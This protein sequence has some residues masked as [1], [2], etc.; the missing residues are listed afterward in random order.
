M[1]QIVG[2]V[3]IVFICLVSSVSMAGNAPL[4]KSGKLSLYVLKS[5]I[6]IEGAELV[7]DELKVRFTD[8]DGAMHV[9]LPAGDYSGSVVINSISLT[10]LLFTVI[11]GEQTQVIVHKPADNIDAVVQIETSVNKLPGQSAGGNQNAIDLNKNNAVI[12][13]KVS[14]FDS[15]KPLGSAKIFISGVNKKIVSDEEGLFEVSL[16]AGMYTL[17]VVM[18]GFNTY[19]IKEIK[20]PD[21]GLINNDIE[22]VPTGVKLAEYLVTAPD[23][24]GS[25]MA[26]EEEK[27]SASTVSEIIGADQMSQ[28]GD[29]DAAGALKRVTGLTLVDGKYI[30]VR[31]L[32]DRY[33]STLLNYSEL[34][35]VDPTRRAVPLDLFPT[36]ALGSVVIQKT[37]SPDLPGDFAGGT[38]ILRTKGIPDNKIRKISLSVGGNSRS[39][40]KDGLTYEGGSTDFIG[41]DDGTREFPPL[42]DALTDGGTK[43]LVRLSD[44]EKEAAGESLANNYATETKKLPPDF[45]LKLNFANR[46][47]MYGSN[48]GWGYNFSFNYKNEWRQR[49][50]ERT[51]FSLDGQGGLVAADT[52]TREKTGNNIDLGAMLNLSAEIGG[53]HILESNTLITRNTTDTVFRD[54]SFLSE[55][56]LNVRDTTLEWVERELINQQF[57]GKHTFYSLNDL[58]IDWHVAYS[59]ANR[60]EPDT[61][62]YRYERQDDGRF[63]FSQEGQ[64]NERTFETLDDE[65]IST[66]IDFTLPVYELFSR[67]A[68]LKAGFAFKENNRESSFVRFRFLTDWSNNNLDPGI[69]YAENPEGILNEENIDPDGYVLRNTTLPTDNYNASQEIASTYLMGEFSLSDSFSFMAGARAEDNNQSVTTFQLTSPEDSTSVI[70]SE[71]DIMPAINATWA[72]SKD[73]QLRFAY[74]ETVNRPDSKELS[75]A[76]YVDAETRDIVI[77]NPNLVKANISSVDIRWE[78]YFSKFE[79]ISVAVFYKEFEAPIERVIRLGA[80]GINTFDN[81]ESAEN[82]GVEFQS[83]FWLSRFF[84]KAASN[85]YMDTNFALIDSNVVLGDAGAQQTN[86]ERA[87]QGQSPWAVNLSLNYENLINEVKSA[88]LFNMSGKRIVNVGTGGLPDAY[89]NPVPVLDFIYSRSLTQGHEDKWGI[90][91]KIQNIL[92]K[93]I[94]TTRGGEVEKTYRAGVTFELALK[95]SWK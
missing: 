15:G 93:E 55:N 59:T 14:S 16:P 28:S 10:D 72:Y 1:K 71:T 12:R 24:E 77:G 6:P 65:I 13:G 89:E 88:L 50:E 78:K 61:R 53:N 30:Y 86:N 38:V 17:S 3:L 27:R 37:Y 67:P 2:A 69:L 64:S 41:I 83:R 8:A 68:K 91:I 7:L 74:S 76:P 22:L 23:L 47:E 36:G 19:T 39:T 45:G 42:L 43:L 87:L 11:P 32:G 44:E 62:F 92:D 70:I 75:E 95:Y 5:G 29:S 54:N 84:G 35:S 57:N 66:G 60:Y 25:A 90:K 51:S 21:A 33:S 81:A 40:F 85:L 63:S 79:N 31:G 9:Y 52:T 46:D 20:L 4:K 48:W 26:L 18:N 34:P 58:K 80:G 73:S 49:V 94:E 82:L 56:E